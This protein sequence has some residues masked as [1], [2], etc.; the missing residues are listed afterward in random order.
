MSTT[1]MHFGPEW[2][3]AKQPH[4]AAR[5]HAIPSPP[6]ASTAQIANSGGSPAPQGASS[7]SALLTPSVPPAQAERDLAHPFK[8]SRDEI[9]QVW[10][11]GGGRG[12]L[13]I[14]VEM[15]EG[16]VREMAGEPACLHELTE[17]EK[18]V[19]A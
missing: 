3:R 4:A 16:V 5:P 15:W 19:K 2:M 18:K 12:P 1:T 9:L 7:Y 17:A 10:K 13:P 14:E 6:P 11:D 8:Y